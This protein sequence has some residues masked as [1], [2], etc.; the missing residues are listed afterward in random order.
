[1]SRHTAEGG[2][3][4]RA[5][6]TAFLIA[7]SFVSPAA[8]TALGQIEIVQPDRPVN[9]ERPDLPHVEPHVAAHPADPLRLLVGAIVTSPE[10][11][12]YWSC[13]VFLTEDGAR[14]WRRHDFALTRCIDPWVL[15][16]DDGSAIFTGIEI[17]DD[18]SGDERFRLVSFRS[19][20]GGKTWPGEPRSLGRAYDHEL[21]TRGDGGGDG[22]EG[23]ARGEAREQGQGLPPRSAGSSAASVYLTARR[24]RRTASGRPRHAVYVARSDDGA[25]S[26]VELAEIRPSNLALNPTGISFLPDG[27]LVISFW[28]FERDV[29]GFEGRGML[30]RGRAWVI[31]SRDGGRTFSEP[32]FVTDDCAS[33]I[34][35]GFPGYP[36]LAAD[37]TTGPHSG[38]LYHACVRPRFEGLSVARSTD[39]GETWSEG[40]VVG[41]SGG[42]GERQARTPMLAVSGEGAIG[43]AW[44]DRRRGPEGVCQ[45]L[46]FSASTDGGLSFVE[47]VRVSSETSCPVTA[48]NGRA[49]RAWPM[50]G[51]YS[52]L[53]GSP[54][55]LFHVVWADSR[56]GVFQLRTATL[57]VAAR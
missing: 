32:L 43:L 42:A 16:L 6:A 23:G 25:R 55:S 39:N 29:D 1:M 24:M 30:D 33:G 13:A 19:E 34:E 15:F 37:S 31:R 10:R 20:D 46:M 9:E 41:S 40:V 36:F 8:R 44:Y 2:S 22:D 11:D 5:F 27:T 3:S 7:V 51:D 47:P 17:G 21:L 53:V 12:G 54:D 38:R 48:G 52:S 14:S 50:G 45:D 4:R 57:R 56:S 18:A 26:F 35:G 49:A 28:D